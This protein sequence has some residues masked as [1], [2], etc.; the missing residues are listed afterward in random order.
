MNAR[1]ALE[2]KILPDLLHSDRGKAFL[3][4]LVQK[5]EAFLADL[6]SIAGEDGASPY[7]KKDFQVLPVRFPGDETSPE[8]AMIAIRMPPAEAPTQCSYIL[9]CHDMKLEN[10]EYYTKEASFGSLSMLCSWSADGAHLNYGTAPE[11]PQELLDKVLGL[12]QAAH[13]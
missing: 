2:H 7:T 10:I 11:D 5:K 9:I 6:F 1:Y 4:T 13:S 8:V 12:Y 3:M